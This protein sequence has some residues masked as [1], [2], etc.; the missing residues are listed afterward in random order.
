MDIQQMQYYGGQYYDRQ[1]YD[2]SQIQTMQY[3]CSP[4][5]LKVNGQEGS[6]VVNT[7]T[8]KQTATLTFR[9]CSAPYVEYEIYRKATLFEPLD[10]KIAVG[11]TDSS[12]VGISTVSFGIGNYEFY[13]KNCPFFLCVVS[14]YVNVEVK[15]ATSYLYGCVSNQCV[16]TVNG[17]YENKEACVIATGCKG[18]DGGGTCNGIQ[19][20]SDCIPTIYVIGG[21]LLVMMMMSQ[22]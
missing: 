9:Y 7:D 17:T 10:V 16:Q 15:K 8:G 13:G 3:N 2:N 12:G 20:G 21:A 22:R 19:I 1:Y 5:N 14:F 4:P 18:I 11:T 6:I